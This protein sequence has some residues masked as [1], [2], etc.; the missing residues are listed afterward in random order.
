[1]SRTP[2]GKAH[3]DSAKSLKA[4]IAVLKAQRS[5]LHSMNDAVVAL[6]SIITEMQ[7]CAPDPVNTLANKAMTELE[8]LHHN[9]E[10]GF[11]HL[12]AVITLR[13]AMNYDLLV[14]KIPDPQ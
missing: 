4:Q 6:T 5:A 7:L 2:D 10:P 8:A 1:K 3:I 12:R 14:K 13:W 9:Q 11:D